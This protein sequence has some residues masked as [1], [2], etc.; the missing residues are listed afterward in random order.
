MKLEHR[1]LGAGVLV[2]VG[3]IVAIV[4]GIIAGNA[5]LGALPPLSSLLAF[6]GLMLSVGGVIALVVLVIFGEET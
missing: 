3:V 1:V 5:S 6:I 2:V 4:A